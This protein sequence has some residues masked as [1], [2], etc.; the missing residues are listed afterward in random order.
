MYTNHANYLFIRLVLG[1][2]P[3]NLESYSFS[4]QVM[5]WATMSNSKYLYMY[6]SK[7]TAKFLTVTNLL[8]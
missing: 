1:F 8:L 5:F 2:C 6:I 4:Q 3:N 7:L